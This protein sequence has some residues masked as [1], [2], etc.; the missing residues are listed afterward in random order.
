MLPSLPAACRV[1]QGTEEGA[2][3]CISVFMLTRCLLPVCCLKRVVMLQAPGMDR[4]ESLAEARRAVLPSLPAAREASQ[5][6]PAEPLLRQARRCET[7]CQHQHCGMCVISRQAC[8]CEDPCQRWFLT[9][10]TQL[11]CPRNPSDEV[12]GRHAGW[13]LPCYARWHA[14][15]GT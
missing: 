15:A 12:G 7:M 9:C 6:L 11:S 14:H 3:A 2:D 1:L 13:R 4:A 10:H 5:A 8:R